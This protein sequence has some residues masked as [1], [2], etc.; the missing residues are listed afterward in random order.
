MRESRFTEHF[1]RANS[2]RF[3]RWVLE[4]GMRFGSAAAWWDAQGNRGRPHNGLDLRLYETPDGGV[5]AVAAG[6]R[7]PVMY[8]GGIVSR[9]PDFLGMTVVVAHDLREGGCRLHTMYGHVA[10]APGTATAALVPDGGII[11]S[12]AEAAGSRV[13][14]HLHLSAAFVP[15]TLPAEDF[16]WRRFD[17]DRAVRFVDPALLLNRFN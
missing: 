13:P 10:P 11:A 15:D 16:S 9:F 6:A 14:P 17:E 8:A 4:P 1:A 12:V 3:R 7:V 2:L 5:E